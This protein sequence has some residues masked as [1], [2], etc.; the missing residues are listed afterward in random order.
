MKVCIIGDSISANL[1]H[2]VVA[3]AMNCK[4]GTA[5]AYS[6]ADDINENEAKEKTKFPDKKGQAKATIIIP[7]RPISESDKCQLKGRWGAVSS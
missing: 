4:L 7:I 1:D 6:T 5:R 3:N 2:R